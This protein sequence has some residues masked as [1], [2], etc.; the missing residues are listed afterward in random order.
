M[1]THNILKHTARTISL[2]IRQT[3][4]FYLL[5]I[6]LTDNL[7]SIKM[8]GGIFQVINII[9]LSA[10]LCY[11][12]SAVVAL[13]A[14]LTHTRKLW[15]NPLFLLFALAANILAVAD[16]FVFINFNSLLCPEYIDI[17]ADTNPE[18]SAGF[19]HTYLTGKTI[20]TIAAVLILG[21]AIAMAICKLRY[22]RHMIWLTAAAVATAYGAVLFSKTVVN[23]ALYRNGGNV[24]QLTSATRVAYAS[25]LTYKNISGISQLSQLADNLGTSAATGGREIKLTL[26]IGESH[27]LYHSSLYNYD[28]P[29]NP[30]LEKRR[31]RG[32]LILMEDAVTTND[33]TH[34][35]MH[36]IFSLGRRGADFFNTPLFP[37][38]FKAAGYTTALYDNM[39]SPGNGISF[40]SDRTLSGKMYDDRN[41]TF[42]END[43]ELAAMARRISGRKSLTIVHL[44]GQHYTYSDRYPHTE[45]FCRFKAEDYDSKNGGTIAHY[46]NACVYNDYVVDGIIGQLA[47]S[48][49]CVVYLS[50]HGEDVFEQNGISGHGFA[51]MMPDMRYQ[52]HVPMFIWCSERFRDGYPE[53]W[54]RIRKAA[55]RPVTTD[56]L[57][58]LLLDIAGIKT[59]YFDP[60][61]SVINE[62]YDSLCPRIVLNSIDYDKRYP[63][64][65]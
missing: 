44:V 18:E 62:Q 50:D 65:Y 12:E 10:F 55:A 7:L 59:E 31:D 5:A 6:S 51:A 37:M 36:S 58:H 3:A 60:T 63:H 14:R 23:Y 15:H 56:D 43:A 19:L 46:D 8:G 4:F 17:I 52:I 33:H 26:V 11:C 64:T 40:M 2:P 53:L 39:Y 57:P 49:A 1:N 21:N 32:E 20:A 16:W 48:V 22:H 9:S 47:D 30:L 61:R 41:E 35:V 54:E 13:Y 27:S 29:T 34:T 24:M 25:F 45:R 38:L 42:T 28:K